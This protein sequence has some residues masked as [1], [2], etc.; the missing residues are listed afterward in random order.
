MPGADLTTVDAIL[1]EVYGPRIENQLQDEVIALKRIERTSSGV[2]ETVGGK[3]VDFPI[4]VKRNHG[5]GYRAEGGLLPAAGKQGY[6]EVHVP[7]RY[8]YGRVRLTGQVMQLA[9]TNVQAFANAMDQEMEGLKN[10]LAK[11]SN[12]VVYGNGKGTL[13]TVV[14]DGANNVVVDNVQY[15][16]LGEKIDIVNASTDAVLAADREITAI[17]ESTKTVTYDGA[18][19]TATTAHVLVRTGSWELEPSGFGIIVDD[20]LVL[21]GLDPATQ[22]KWA[23]KVKANSGTNRA[24]SE[25]LM[26]ETADDVRRQGSKISV[27]FGSLG[28]RRAYFN[29]LTQQRRYTDT[30]EFAGGFTGLAFNYGT[31]IPMVEDTDAPP[32][33]LFFVTE[34]EIKIYRNKEWHWADD[35][36][37]VLKWVHDYDAWEALIRQYWEMGTSKRNAHAVLK[38]ITE[39]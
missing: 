32:N 14:S 11:D 28:V 30:K 39:G 3:Y 29:L 12:R 10:D 37:S 33:R 17:A 21:H 25:G 16:E 15:L 2:V 18:D 8:G 27:I 31:E 6:A 23:A 13:A 7:L 24:L 26:I 20:T 9:K 22:P 35:D 34:S 38:D 36:G 4:R 1:K 5:M 19:V